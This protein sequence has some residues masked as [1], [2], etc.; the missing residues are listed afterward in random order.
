[1]PEQ[2]ERKR[3]ERP[4]R[5]VLRVLGIDP[6]SRFTGFGLLAVEGNRVA[7]VEAGRLVPAPGRGVPE[8]L[9]ELAAG[10]A[11]LL[12][13]HE[14]DV[15]A[16]ERTF[17]GVNSRSLI[18]LAEARGALLAVLAQRGIPVREYAPAEVKAAVAGGQA[19]KEEIGRMVGLLLGPAGRGLPAD[20][21]DAVAVALCYS[22]RRHFDRLSERGESEAR[23]DRKR[24][25]TSPASRAN[26]PPCRRRPS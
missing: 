6:G 13:R 5:P 2:A 16:V 3:D 26:V 15:A 25:L 11:A 20:A 24:A 18:V 14:V 19:T 22:R 7:L 12:D 4:R 21:A 8:R 17:H 9:G 1:M 10:L 23:G